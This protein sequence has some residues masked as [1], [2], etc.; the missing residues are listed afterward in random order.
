[1]IDEWAN[2]GNRFDR[3]GECLLTAFAGEA[4]VG[5]GGLT[6][7]P[8]IDGALRMRRFY[9]DPSMRRQGIGR[10]LASSLVERA[11]VMTTLL[12]VHSGSEDA[13]VFWEALGFQPC[14]RDGYSHILRLA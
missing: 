13:S 3:D 2:G 9:I 8:T 4:L 6:L 7:E 11:R 12:T 5:I 10:M 1:L 14:F